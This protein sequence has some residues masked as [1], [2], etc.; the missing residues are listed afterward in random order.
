MYKLSIIEDSR[1]QMINGSILL[2]VYIRNF[3]A[4]VNTNKVKK[5]YPREVFSF[6]EKL[7]R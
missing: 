7:S 5:R 2:F 6:F 1:I 4:R 3:K